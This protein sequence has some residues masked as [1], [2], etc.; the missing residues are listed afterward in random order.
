MLSSTKIRRIKLVAWKIHLSDALDIY[1]KNQLLMP[2]FSVSFLWK[3]SWIEHGINSS[4]RAWNCSTIVNLHDRV[5]ETPL[6]GAK[7]KFSFCSQFRNFAKVTANFQQHVHVKS[8]WHVLLIRTKIIRAKKI[9][10]ISVSDAKFYGSAIRVQQTLCS[11]E[12]RQ[13]WENYSESKS[14]LWEKFLTRRWPSVRD[15]LLSDAYVNHRN[16]SPIVTPR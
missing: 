5:Y 16:R 6:L 9:P 8:Y 13:K 12:A 4:S 3:W 11:C 7:R 2:L 14:L 10:V 1:G 15:E